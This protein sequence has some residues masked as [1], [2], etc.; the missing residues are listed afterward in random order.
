LLPNQF[1]SSQNNGLNK[2]FEEVEY[3]YFFT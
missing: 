1:E 3:G 2:V